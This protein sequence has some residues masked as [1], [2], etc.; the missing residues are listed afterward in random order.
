MDLFEE[1]SDQELLIT[2]VKFLGL[3]QQA[4][5]FTRGM[6]TE[7][8]YLYPNDTVAVKDLYEYVLSADLRSVESMTRKIQWF[9]AVG[10][11]KLEKDVTSELNIKNRKELNRNVRQGRIDYL[12]AAAEELATLS[13]LMPEPFKT[14]FLKASNSID[15]ILKHYELEIE[16]YVGGNDL[17]FERA[18]LNEDNPVMLDIFALQVRPPDAEFPSGLTIKQSILHQ[19][20]GAY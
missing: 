5:D 15:I 13:P 2:N 6:R 10:E 20:T 16:H 11:M 17:G 12:I 7:R 19:L 9:N 3:K 18:V 1:Y 14:D 8:N 4:W